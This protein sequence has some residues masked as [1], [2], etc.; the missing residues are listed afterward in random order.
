MSSRRSRR[1]TRINVSDEMLE[2]YRRGCEL[3]DADHADADAEG[4]LHVE[5][6]ALSKRLEWALLKRA[7]HEVSVFDDLSGDPPLYT[8]IP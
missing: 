6:I 1:G 8:P 4:S 3:R 2:L 7:P 5:F